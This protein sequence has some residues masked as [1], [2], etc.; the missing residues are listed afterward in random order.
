[1]VV[2]YALYKRYFHEVGYL[3][4]PCMTTNLVMQAN[5]RSMQKPPLLSFNNHLLYKRKIRMIDLNNLQTRLKIDILY[6]ITADS[7]Y[8]QTI[9]F[10]NNLY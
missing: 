1:M 2:R 9:V 8:T 10:S 4:V 6:F 3:S 5:Y 7:K